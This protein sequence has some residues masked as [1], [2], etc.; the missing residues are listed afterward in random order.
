MAG[1]IRAFIA[2]ELPESVKKAAADA[3]A[4]LGRKGLRLRWV[5]PENMHLTLKFLG[6]TDPALVPELAAALGQSV[7]GAAPIAL[8]AEGLG[9][10]PNPARARVVWMGLSGE[11]ARLAALAGGLDSLLSDLGFE[12]ETRPF[13]AHLTLGRSR[14]RVDGGLLARAMAQYAQSGRAPAAFTL[15]RLV[16]FKSDLRPQGPIYTRLAESMLE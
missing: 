9:V 12:P 3:V 4:Y 1:A 10:F 14:D 6:D 5:K 16:L 8:S 7:S 15:D 2:A 13:A 11:T